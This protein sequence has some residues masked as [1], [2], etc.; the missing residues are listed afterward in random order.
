MNEI[1]KNFYKEMSF[2]TNAGLYKEYFKSLPEDINKLRD[3]VCDQHIHKMRVFR[4]F[5]EKEVSKNFIWYNCLY[6]ALNTSTAMTA[7]IFRL[8]SNGFYYNKPLNKR[9][10][11]TCR[12]ISILFAS[13]MK[14]KGIPCRCRSGFAPYLYEDYNV[15]HWINEYWSEKENRWIAIDAQVQ[16]TSRTYDKDVNLYDINS[17]FEYPA[18]LWLKARNGEL[19]NFDRY[20]KYTAYKG[21]DILAHTLFLDFNALMNLELPYRYTPEFVNGENFNKLTKEDYEE[22]DNLATLMLN[23]D[24]NFNELK[25]IWYTNEKFRLLNG[26]YYNPF[27]KFKKS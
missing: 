15:D 23:P 26:P 7:E 25:N 24:K 6:D 16:D 21:M 14:S 2:Y 17:K 1:I 9:I 19:T 27:I 18:E 13:I 22:I 20:T 8:D 12:Y 10:V 4:S 11:V 3:L 5:D